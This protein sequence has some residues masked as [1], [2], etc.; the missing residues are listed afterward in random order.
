[1]VVLAAVAIIAGLVVIWFFLGPIA[2]RF[3][4]PEAERLDIVRVYLL[5]VGGGL[6]IWQI[7]IASRRAASAERIAELTAL[8]NITE[9]LNAAI[10]NLG[11]DNPVVRIGAL[12]QLHHIARDAANYRRTVFRIVETY[13][14]SIDPESSEWD[15]ATQMLNQRIADGGVYYDENAKNGA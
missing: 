5:A 9:R 4:L 2:E 13:L 11:S 8:G 3:G 12:Y 10:A 7:F 6:L 1:M 14:A 15:I